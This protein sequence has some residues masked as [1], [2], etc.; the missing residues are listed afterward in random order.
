MGDCE[1]GHDLHQIPE[2][3]RRED[4]RGEKQEVTVTLL[5]SPRQDAAAPDPAPQAVNPLI[6][7]E[8]QPENRIA[9]PEDLRVRHPA[10]AQTKEYWAAQK[11]G[12]VQY[13]RTSWN[14]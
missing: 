9:V 6:A 4:E 13:A 3:L 12:E 8:L 5:G 11:R 10:I 14:I 7:A 1:G 2:R